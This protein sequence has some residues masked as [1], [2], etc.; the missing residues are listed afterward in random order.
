MSYTELILLRRWFWEGSERC[1]VQRRS[2]WRDAG[3]LN[4]R[5]DGIWFVIFAGTCPKMV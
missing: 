5:G 4:G 2:T 1:T 3:R